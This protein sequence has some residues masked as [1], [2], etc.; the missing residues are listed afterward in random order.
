MQAQ[1]RHRGRF[2]VALLMTDGVFSR[3]FFLT[4]DRVIAKSKVECGINAN[5]LYTDRLKCAPG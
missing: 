5:N 4:F 2:R 3:S 1:A